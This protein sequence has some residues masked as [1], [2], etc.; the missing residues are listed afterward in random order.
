M[1]RSARREST[2]RNRSINASASRLFHQLQGQQSLRGALIAIAGAGTFGALALLYYLGD[3]AKEPQATTPRQILFTGAGTLAALVIAFRAILELRHRDALERCRGRMLP[4]RTP[5]ENEQAGQA[6]GGSPRLRGHLLTSIHLALLTLG[7]ALV[8]I[9]VVEAIAAAVATN[10]DVTGGLT[11]GELALREARRRSGAASQEGSGSAEAGRSR[12]GSTSG[13][14]SAGLV[15]PGVRS[16]GLRGSGDGASVGDLLS[17]EPVLRVTSAR[18]LPA[19]SL[20]LR[21][22]VLDQYDAQGV[23][24]ERRSGRG[25]T[26]A[27]EADGWALVPDREEDRRS[28]AGARGT[29]VELGVEFVGATNGVVYAPARLT[30]VETVRL[31]HAPGSALYLV[32]TSDESSYSVRSVIPRPTL[33]ELRA[34]RASG[35][36]AALPPAAAETPRAYAL[37]SL[38]SYARAVIGDAPSDVDAVIAVVS[39][40]RAAFGYE[41]YDA[42]FLSPE[43]CTDL[44]QKGSG[45]CSHFA[46][47]ATLLLRSVGIPARIAV[48][49]VAREPLDHPQG[50][51]EE[52]GWL[53]RARDGHAW[54]EV[55]FEGFGWLPFDPTP[56]DATAGGVTSGWAPLDSAEL[57]DLIQVQGS[58]RR[59]PRTSSLGDWVLTGLKSLVQRLR[60]AFMEPSEPADEVRKS[61]SAGRIALG[62]AAAV[63]AITAFIFWRRRNQR[64]REAEDGPSTDHAEI[65][66]VSSQGGVSRPI[67]LPDRSAV[68]ALMDALEGSGLRQGRGETPSGFARR[69]AREDSRAKGLIGPIQALIAR[70]TLRRAL[71]PDEAAR[72]A[73]VTERLKREPVPLA[74]GTDQTEGASNRTASAEMKDF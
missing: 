16:S 48:G 3:L 41:L 35:G 15:G 23:L 10:E 4:L 71:A 61:L 19:P 20:H 28:S 26:L 56:G 39:H 12:S 25:L 66:N 37:E 7:G 51:N 46:S 30:A 50:E 27:A 21:G 67:G 69:A 47:L 17:D 70:A 64:T 65:R 32:Q 40:L 33:S 63:A 6:A 8:L 43:R 5:A 11:S 58:R 13:A 42:S 60:G 14:Q 72:V 68:A 1:T 54:I 44:L 18:A 2:G 52:P 59:D 62:F 24:Q 53:V 31:L 74:E 38:T 57:T 36:S 22:L 45:S 49:Y 55:P 9:V 73:K 34:V 29:L